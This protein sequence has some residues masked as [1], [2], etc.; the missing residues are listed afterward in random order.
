MPRRTFEQV[1]ADEEAHDAVHSR[2][3][4]LRN[5]WYFANVYQFICL[6]GDALKIDNEIDMDV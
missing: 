2:V 4:A 3:K 1:Q 5:S 6:F